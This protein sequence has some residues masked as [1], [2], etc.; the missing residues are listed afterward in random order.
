MEIQNGHETPIQLIT[1]FRFCF[2]EDRNDMM[3]EF[4]FV[5]ER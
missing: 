1:E 4:S 5:H 2:S 3:R